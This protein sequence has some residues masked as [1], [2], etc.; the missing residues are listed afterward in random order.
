MLLLVVGVVHVQY[1]IMERCVYM[2]NI[3][4]TDNTRFTCM[5]LYHPV[6]RVRFICI[7]YFCYPVILVLSVCMVLYGKVWH[8]IYIYI[9]S[10]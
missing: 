2:C 10:H 1:Y 6:C 8:V 9:S 4:V 3:K 5:S 7:G